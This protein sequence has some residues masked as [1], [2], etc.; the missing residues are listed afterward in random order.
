MGGRKRA[1][2]TPLRYVPCQDCHQRI[3]TK[4]WRKR[5]VCQPCWEQLRK[6][7]RTKAVEPAMG[8]L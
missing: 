7:H 8:A 2:G 3:S 4:L 6:L 1:W 5:L